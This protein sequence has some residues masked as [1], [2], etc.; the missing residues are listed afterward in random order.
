MI[1]YITLIY[2]LS[3]TNDPPTAVYCRPQRCDISSL[4][5][6]FC[7]AKIQ[8]NRPN[9]VMLHTRAKRLACRHTDCL[10]APYKAGDPQGTMM[11]IPLMT[12]TGRRYYLRFSSSSKYFLFML[13]GERHTILSYVLPNIPSILLSISQSFIIA[14]AGYY[15][16]IPYVYR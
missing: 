15:H 8:L 3:C 1:I 11:L 14:D 13:F 7:M 16:L 10:I 9:N 5:M 4:S 6:N 12:M 2:I